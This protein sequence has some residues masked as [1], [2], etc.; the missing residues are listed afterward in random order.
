[1]EVSFPD[2]PEFSFGEKLAFEKLVLGLYASGH[3]LE[4]YEDL[5]RRNIGA[6]LSDF[7]VDEESG[8]AGVQD[9]ASVWVGGLVEKRTV[10][11]TRSGAAMMILNLEDMTDSIEVLCFPRETDSFR[12]K[13]EEGS[14]VFVRGRVSLGDDAKGKLIAEK[15]L[16]FDE[17]E[18][19]AYVLFEDK[20]SYRTGERRLTELLQGAGCVVALRKERQTKRLPAEP[21]AVLTPEIREALLKEFGPD[22]VAIREKKLR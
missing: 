8:E 1:M 3:P 18:Q 17:L 11:T 10:R 14:R 5:L 7:N 12:E 19:E 4:E 15:I 16:R 21:G 22:R 6:R 20:N 9:G 13:T 2:I